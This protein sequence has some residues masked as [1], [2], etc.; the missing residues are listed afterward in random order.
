M[1]HDKS[2]YGWSRSHNSCESFKRVCLQLIEHKSGSKLI[3]VLSNVFT[4]AEAN[5]NDLG[6]W[7]AAA[8]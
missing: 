7:F 6:R 1:Q 5:V 8:S 4:T 3:A 2:D